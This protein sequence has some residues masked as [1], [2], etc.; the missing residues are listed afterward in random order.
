MEG[1]VDIV[2]VVFLQALAQVARGEGLAR[3]PDGIDA[4]R[5]VDGVRGQ[6]HHGAQRLGIGGGVVERDRAAVAVADQHAILDRRA[7]PA[8]RGSTSSASISM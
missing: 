2:A 4:D 8:A 7:W 1:A 3:A 5:F 6:R